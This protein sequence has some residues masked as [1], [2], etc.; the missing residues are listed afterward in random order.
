MTKSGAGLARI[1]YSGREAESVAG[2]GLVKGARK[3]GK[4]VNNTDL[5]LK[6][7]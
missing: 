4:A 7:E 1:K 6:H 3:N 5:F 2:K